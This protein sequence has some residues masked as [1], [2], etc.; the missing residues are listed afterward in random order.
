[1]IL[2]LEVNKDSPDFGNLVLGVPPINTQNVKTQ[3]L[4]DN[5]ETIVLGGVYEQTKS[6]T[7]NRV[8]FFGDLPLIG[9]LFRSRSENE[10]KDELLIFVTPKIIKDRAQI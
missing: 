2:D 7:I 10:T 1:V 3:V 6:N 8:P 5:G 9:V 4:V